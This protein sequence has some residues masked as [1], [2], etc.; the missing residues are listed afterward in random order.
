MTIAQQ[1]KVK[2]FPFI[3][4]DSKG[5]PIYWECSRG[6]WEKF[7][8]DTNGNEIYY[9]DSSGY[10]SKRDVDTNGDQIYFEDS[11][12][13]IQDNRH[14]TVELSM[15]EIAAKFGITVSQLKIKKINI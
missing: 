8:Y 3:I 4:K 11:N 1:L 7:E 10:W 2:D 5:N 12:G 15:D 6:F 14:K 9:E 13:M